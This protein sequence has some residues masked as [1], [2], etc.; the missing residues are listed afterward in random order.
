[1]NKQKFLKYSALSLVFLQSEAFFFSSNA[2]NY[3][4]KIS[5]KGKFSSKYELE[6]FHRRFNHLGFYPF[7]I[8]PSIYYGMNNI[9]IENGLP[10]VYTDQQYLTKME[11]MIKDA[12]RDYC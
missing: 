8:L 9:Y 10:K 4:N 5:E 2:F 1:M 3:Y 7:T 11:N 12:A 6:E